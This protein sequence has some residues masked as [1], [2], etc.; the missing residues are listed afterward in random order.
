MKKKTKE[1]ISFI[2]V[3]VLIAGAV[4]LFTAQT[5]NETTSLPL[6]AWSVGA[7]NASG[8]YEK[9]STALYTSEM[10]GCRGLEVV[11]DFEFSGTYTVYLYNLNKE[12]LKSTGEL[13]GEYKLENEALRD[14]ACFARIQLTPTVP[15]GSTDFKLYF[16]DVYTY[17]SNITVNVSKDQ[18]VKDLDLFGQNELDESI[19]YGYDYA[20]KISLDG[21]SELTFVGVVNVGYKCSFVN[22]EGM[23]ISNQG[24]KDGNN[25]IYSGLNAFTEVIVY[26]N[27]GNEFEIYRTK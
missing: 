12:L 27:E 26:Y 5:K 7:I 19:M 8:E 24:E 22:Y 18:S 2:L 20:F 15:D 16:Y 21:I 10:F 4:G 23:G 9:S 17:A 11:P 14:V 3:I 6:T 1:F 25:V 13:K